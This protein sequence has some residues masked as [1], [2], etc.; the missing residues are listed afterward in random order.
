[1]N[2]VA[3]R[4]L[5][6]TAITKRINETLSRIRTEANEGKTSLSVEVH[7]QHMA[8]SFKVYFKELGYV[9]GGDEYCVDISWL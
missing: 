5:A 4:K 1:M 3:A 7:G 2:A 8:D 9:V 6:D